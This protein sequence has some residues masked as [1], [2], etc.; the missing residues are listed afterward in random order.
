MAYIS[1]NLNAVAAIDDADFDRVKP[2]DWF[3]SG[4]GYAAGFV[5][6]EGKFKLVY[7]HRFLLD[8]QRSSP[9]TSVKVETWHRT[10]QPSSETM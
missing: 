9:K 1:L 6:V 5:P 2:Y 4:S 8:A 10:R 3:L 7:L